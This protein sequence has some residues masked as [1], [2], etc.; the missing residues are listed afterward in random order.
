MK[1]PYAY[2]TILLAA[3]ILTAHTDIT[4]GPPP[5]GWE[6]IDYPDGTG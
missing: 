6:L 1:Y 5:G 2:A 4:Y 3:A